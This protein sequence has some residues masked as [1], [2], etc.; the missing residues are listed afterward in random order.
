MPRGLFA[1]SSL[2]MRGERDAVG[3]T[4]LCGEQMVRLP[5][6]LHGGIIQGMWAIVI[7]KHQE[8]LKISVY[9]MLK[10]F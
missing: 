4:G 9:D 8:R 10:E 1:L 6:N 2:V 7:R 5:R 3:I